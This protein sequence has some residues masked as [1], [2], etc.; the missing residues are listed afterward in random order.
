MPTF[1]CELLLFFSLSAVVAGDDGVDDEFPMVDKNYDF[2][3]QNFGESDLFPRP[4]NFTAPKMLSSSVYCFS[5]A[6]LQP[7]HLPDDTWRR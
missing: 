2:C 4:L 1:C 7:I 3:P 6:L 5:I